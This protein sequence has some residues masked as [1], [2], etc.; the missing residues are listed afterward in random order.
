MD[1]FTSPTR[2]QLRFSRV[3]VEKM[4]SCTALESWYSSTITSRKR[5]PISFATGKTVERFLPRSKSS[6]LCSRSEK[7]MILR[8]RLALR[9]ASS[10]RHT[11]ETMPRTAP[12]VPCKSSKSWQLGSAKIF[13]FFLTPSMQALRITLMRSAKSW[14]QHFFVSGILPKGISLCKR[15]SSQVSQPYSFSS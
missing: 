13:T 5:L 2:K 9:N 15:I 10:N 3:M 11:N 12:K 8:L 6:V 7:S 4:A 1:C 14:L